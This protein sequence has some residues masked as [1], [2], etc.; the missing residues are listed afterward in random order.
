MQKYTSKG[1]TIFRLWRKILEVKKMR[2]H[3]GKNASQFPEK[4]GKFIT[5]GCFKTA[6]ILFAAATNHMLAMFVHFKGLGPENSSPYKSG[7]KTTERIISELQGK[8]TQIQS[9]DAQPTVSDILNRV[10]SVQFNQLAEDRLIQ[11]G[12]KKQASTNRKRLSHSEKTVEKETYQYP[13]LFS[14]FLDQQRDSYNEGIIEGKELFEKYCEAGASYLKKKDLWN[15]LEK[16]ESVVPYQNQFTGSLPVGYGAHKLLNVQSHKLLADMSSL[17]E[18]KLHDDILFEG[19]I[20][21]EQKMFPEEFCDSDNANDIKLKK[22][23]SFRNKNN[24]EWYVSKA[25]N[26]RITYLHIKRAIKIIIPREYVSRERSRRHIA[27]NYLPGLEPINSDHNVQKYRFYAFKLSSGYHLGK[28]IFLEDQGN[29]VV[30]SNSANAH[31]TFRALIL[32]EQGENQFTYSSPLKIS[33]W[34]N[35][36]RVYSEVHLTSIN[37][38]R[39]LLGKNSENIFRGIQKKQLEFEDFMLAKKLSSDVSLEYVEVEDIVDRKA[40]KLSYQYLY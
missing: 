36:D 27:S 26:D 35:I 23:Q 14:E 15:F 32:S 30:S 38:G 1:I 28:I 24:R 6:E 22:E 11:N 7:T 33:R 16:K 5:V 21:D 12:A 39:Y 2:L 40:D 29:P 37:G 18:E 10:S 9:L 34:L 8:T 17:E 3:S 19:D 13:K 31:M 25:L 20:D 4:R